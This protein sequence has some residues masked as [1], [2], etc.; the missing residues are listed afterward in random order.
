M[1]TNCCAILMCLHKFSAT[2]VPG[3]GIVCLSH[4]GVQS[5]PIGQ[6]SA[7]TPAKYVTGHVLR[8][9]F[10]CVRVCTFQP[11]YVYMSVFV[12]THVQIYYDRYESSLRMFDL[13]TPMSVQAERIVDMTQVLLVFPLARLW[14][15]HRK[16]RWSLSLGRF[17]LQEGPSPQPE[18]RKEG[19]L[20]QYC[21]I[22]WTNQPIPTHQAP[23]DL[24]VECLEVSVPSGEDQS[25]DQSI[26]SSNL[27]LVQ[28]SDWQWI[29]LTAI[30]NATHER[31]FAQPFTAWTYRL[32]KV[33]AKNGWSIFGSA[34]A[35]STQRV[36]L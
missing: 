35:I 7:V 11:T 9:M 15:A 2:D 10:V 1:H 3:E 24:F 6:H 29:R 20:Y 23:N 33:G 34:I 28:L 13:C 19:E 17:L 18:T 36:D 32:P 22:S 12:C 5:P 16:Q 31:L 30:V 21:S 4:L 8:R 14:F 25:I 27:M 26:V